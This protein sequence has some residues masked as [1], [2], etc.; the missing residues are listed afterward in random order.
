MK[1]VYLFPSMGQ[2]ERVEAYKYE[3]PYTQ[4]PNSGKTRISLSAYLQIINSSFFVATFSMIENTLNVARELS[5]LHKDFNAHFQCTLLV[6][7]ASAYFNEK[8]FPK[9]NRFERTLRQYIYFKQAY[10]LTDLDKSLNN[11]TNPATKKALNEEI[12]RVKDAF[13]KKKLEDMDFDGIFR[14][15][16]VDS[17]LCDTIKRKFFPDASASSNAYKVRKADYIQFIESI[18]ENILWNSL[19]AGALDIVKENFKSIQV[20]RNHVMHAHNID[21]E[22]FHDADRMID[23]TQKALDA[24]IGSFIQEKNISLIPPGIKD[25]LSTLIAAIEEVSYNTGVNYPIRY[26]ERENSTIVEE[27]G[28]MRIIVDSNKTEDNNNETDIQ[29]SEIPS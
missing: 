16:F 27:D 23:E 17:V 18:D 15:L 3:R 24:E 25:A 11:E 8:L 29:T 22:T 6:N 5:S 19:S 28:T 12:K 10:Y 20:I 14:L 13:K 26:T 4:G 9:I 2:H 7:E 21:Y 1:L